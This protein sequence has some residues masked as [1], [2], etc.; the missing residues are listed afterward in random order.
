[1]KKIIGTIAL[2]LVVVLVY[3]LAGCAVRNGDKTL[4]KT[5]LVAISNM[6]DKAL[7]ES[8]VGIRRSAINL[9]DF[10]NSLEEFQNIIRDENVSSPK[11]VYELIFD[12]NELI[13]KIHHQ[14]DDYA[15]LPERLQKQI[16]SESFGSLSTFLNSHNGGNS[17]FAL[18]TLFSE[19]GSLSFRSMDKPRVLVFVFETGYPVMVDFTPETDGIIS[20]IAHWL[21]VDCKNIDS[22]ESLISK[23]YLNLFQSLDVRKIDF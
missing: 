12:E 16:L 9:V 10:D 21:D 8:F 7:N 11:A 19:K 22:E 14:T 3:V 17:Y 20:Y 13:R 15:D 5:G 4:V 6:K 18:L 1:M 2:C 23:L